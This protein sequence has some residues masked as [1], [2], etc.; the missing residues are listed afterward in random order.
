VFGVRGIS[1][2]QNWVSSRRRPRLVKAATLSAAARIFATK[3][4]R[5]SA[6]FRLA[7]FVKRR[8]C[9]IQTATLLFNYHVIF[10]FAAR[11]KY[12][13]KMSSAVSARS[14]A[15][16][17]VIHGPFQNGFK[18]RGLSAPSHLFV[19][20]SDADQKTRQRCVSHLVTL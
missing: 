19:H 11:R 3:N 13:T 10:A 17:R 15:L 8:G 2:Q 6:L 20:A 18:P 4:V 14:L 12:K 7:L 9:I 16:A 5:A 1:M